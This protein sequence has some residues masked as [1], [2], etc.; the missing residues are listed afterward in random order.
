MLAEVEPVYCNN[1]SSGSLAGNKV[2]P[3]TERSR[4]QTSYS[5]G[6][7][8]LCSGMLQLGIFP[9]FMTYGFRIPAFIEKLDTETN[10]T[11]IRGMIGAEVLK[12]NFR[13]RGL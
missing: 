9:H 5:N 3:A 12:S 8:E 6:T 11:E 2:P 4:E 7:A 13:T 10:E 1:S